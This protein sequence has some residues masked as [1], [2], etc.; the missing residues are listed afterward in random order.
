MQISDETL[1][2]LAD[3]E[4]DAETA[5]RVSQAVAAD[6]ALAARVVL[7]DCVRALV[8]EGRW[9]G[10]RLMAEPPATPAA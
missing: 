10:T 3:D 1:M 8:A 7:L 6:P 5:R 9:S 2:A 4:L